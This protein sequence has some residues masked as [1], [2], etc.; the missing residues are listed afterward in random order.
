MSCSA[1]CKHAKTCVATRPKREIGPGLRTLNLIDFA[2]VDL[3][4]AIALQ[5]SRARIGPNKVQIGLGFL[6]RKMW[7]ISN[8]IPITHNSFVRDMVHL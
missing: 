1:S 7:W 6:A 8:E 2:C 4:P 3:Q 5:P